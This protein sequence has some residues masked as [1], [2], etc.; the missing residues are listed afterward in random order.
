M[1]KWILGFLFVFG[2]QN[3]SAFTS[4]PFKE[5]LFDVVEKNHSPVSYRSAR[6]L[7]FGFL[8]LEGTSP[9]T[10][11]IDT[12][13]CNE[14]LTNQDFSGANQLA[15][16]KIP[17]NNIINVEHAWP[18]SHFTGKFPKQFQKAD[19]HSLFPTVSQINSIRGNFPF[20]EVVT[21]K[22]TPCP[23]AALGY[24]SEGEQVFEPDDV[25]KG[26]MARAIFYFSTRYKAMVDKNQEETLRRWHQMDPPDQHE[27]DI[28]QKI[29]EIQKNRNPF[30]DNPEYVDQILDF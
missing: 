26:D 9:Q 10:Y 3:G 13:Y 1:F 11:S 5:Q 4:D 21:P 8:F 27:I 29:F 28:N 7:I 17:D 30:V 14:T 16:M 22:Q 19:L 2:M 23:E 18:Q 24:S 6:E 25:I 12:Y 20:G 15:P